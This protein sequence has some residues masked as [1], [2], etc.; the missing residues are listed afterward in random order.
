MKLIFLGTAG[1]RFMTITQK[2][3]TGGTILEMDGEIIHI[4]PGPG[5]LVRA[6]EFGFNLKS[7]T[8]VLITHAHPDHYTDAEFVIIAMTKGGK[9]KC[10]FLLAN[11]HV[12]NGSM[13][14]RYRPV[15]STYVLNLLDE[16]KIMKPGDMFK[17]GKID[18]TAVR[19]KHGEP[20]ALG[21]VIKGSSTIGLTGDGEYYEG[22]A[23]A[24]KGCDYLL[25]NCLR[26]RELKWPEH[27]NSEGATKLISQVRPKLAVLKDIGMKMIEGVA[28]KEAKWIE[29]NTGVKTI[30]A[31][32]GMRITNT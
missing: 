31:R 2:R 4:D 20:K 24:F 1:G 29:E 23:D 15:V 13:D 10:G 3:A 18:I 28:E 19:A 30:V 8:G 6:K 25:V 27:M 32:D 17:I 26:P 7:L 5:A 21:F 16:H 22:M 12:I 14:G 9:K 11:D